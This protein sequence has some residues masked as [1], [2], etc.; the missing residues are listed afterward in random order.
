M[1]NES[2]STSDMTFLNPR[3]CGLY[4]NGASRFKTDPRTGT[5]TSEID[6]ELL[7]MVDAYLA[8]EKSPGE[9]IRPLDDVFEKRVLVPTYYDERYHDGIRAL[10]KILDV[11]G[12][13]LGELV[14]E[15]VI[16]ARGGHGSPGNDQRT[17]SIPYIKVSDV[18]A[19]R[20][21]VNPTNLVTAAVAKRMWRG[22]SSGLEAWD[23][24]T[25]NRASANIGEF[26]MLLPGEE[27]VVLTKE[28]FVFRIRDRRVWDPYY[29][30]WALSL[31]GVREQW[32]RIALMQ[33]NREDCGERWKEIILPNPPNKPWAQEMSKAFRDY[34]SAIAAAKEKF[35]REVRGSDFE[36][37]ANVLTEAERREE[38]ETETG[39]Q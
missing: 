4:K 21:N 10:L 34:F 39:S 26:A 24:V 35:L 28:V 29:L 11:P 17:G 2:E 19:L 12:I 5:R 14:E 9:A 16:A 18:R 38:T 37:V 32:R 6:N 3:T 23:V 8:G 1:M 30:L 27:R 31:R 25:P 36:F 33:T 13:T 15:G 22:E 7:E 20:I